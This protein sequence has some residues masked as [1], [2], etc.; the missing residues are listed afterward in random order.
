M[1]FD[2]EYY[3]PRWVTPLLQ[4][5]ILDHPVVFLTG[6]RQVGKSTLLMNA[7]P[8]RDWRYLSLDDFNELRQAQ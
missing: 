2:P 1:H 8:F 3:R 5:A 6:A 4:Q 7:D